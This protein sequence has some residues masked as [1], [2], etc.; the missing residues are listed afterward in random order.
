MQAKLHT[1]YHRSK[2]LLRFYGKRMRRASQRTPRSLCVKG[3]A[4]FLAPI[5]FV[6]LVHGFRST[7]MVHVSMDEVM[8]QFAVFQ[9][10]GSQTLDE[11]QSK[12]MAQSFKR[13]VVDLA[14]SKRWIMVDTRGC[15]GTPKALGKI[16]DVTSI[17]Q[18][19][20]C[21]VHP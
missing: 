10:K 8:K 1:L 20:C 17:V 5:V 16:K 19:V 21:G 18:K 11:A 7:Q 6:L 2:R 15:W 12:E 14:R 13:C 3:G 9:A 4:L